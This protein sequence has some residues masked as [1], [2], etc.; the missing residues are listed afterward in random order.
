MLALRPST[1]TSIIQNR[2]Q[3]HHMQ[4]K[5]QLFLQLTGSLSILEA[6][7]RAKGSLISSTCF[8]R[9]GGNWTSA[10]E[11]LKRRNVLWFDAIG[12][13]DKERLSDAMAAS[14]AEIIL[15]Q[16]IEVR[17]E[18]REMWGGR[19]T[20]AVASKQLSG[21]LCSS[22]ARQASLIHLL[23]LLPYF[24]IAPHKFYRYLI[25]PD[26]L[27]YKLSPKLSIMGHKS[28]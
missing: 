7:W 2:K 3:N 20:A 22:A 17:S 27:S 11:A 4:R 23:L 16:T 1:T 10:A 25:D 26:F 5:L 13:H 28:D 9:K 15:C 19:T 14:N 21:W 24:H 12:W 6:S 18:R 8:G